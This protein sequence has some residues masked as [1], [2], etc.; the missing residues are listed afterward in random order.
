MTHRLGAILK[1]WSNFGRLE[2]TKKEDIRGTPDL[3]RQAEEET[4][5][6]TETIRVRIEYGQEKHA[7]NGTIECVVEEEE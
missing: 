3:E 6:R 4:Q 5:R 1:L 7:E 2:I